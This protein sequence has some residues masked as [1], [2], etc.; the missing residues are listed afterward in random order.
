MFIR[1]CWVIVANGG[2]ETFHLSE[3]YLLYI[4]ICSLTQKM[5][6][7]IKKNEMKVM[8]KNKSI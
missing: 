3:K 4:L 5:Y 8:V 7:V 1:T 2:P 6:D